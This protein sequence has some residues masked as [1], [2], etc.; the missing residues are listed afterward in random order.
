MYHWTVMLNN[1]EGTRWKKWNFTATRTDF[2]LQFVFDGYLSLIA[3]SKSIMKIFMLVI[4]MNL[5]NFRSDHLSQ[6]A[7]ALSWWSSSVRGWMSSMK[8]SKLV[9][10]I[11]RQKMMSNLITQ[12]LHEVVCD[13]SLI[14]DD[15]HPCVSYVVRWQKLTLT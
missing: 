2:R 9:S 12:L 10:G 15:I 7:G 1:S 3:E 11:D 13:G 14:V 6:P 4:Q 5:L 8:E